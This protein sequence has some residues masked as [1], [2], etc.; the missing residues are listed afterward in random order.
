M[1]LSGWMRI[2]IIAIALCGCGQVPPQS[3]APAKKVAAYP[4]GLT[5][6]E[7]FNL[8]SKCAEL[9]DKQAQILGL[10]GIALT[11]EV[12]SHYNPDTNRCYAETVTTKNFSFTEKKPLPDN[13]LTT[14]LHDAQTKKL[15]MSA[16]QEGDKRVG[17][18]YTSQDGLVFDYDKVL[19]QINQLMQEDAVQ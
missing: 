2:G 13:Y 14:S 5:A 11:S 16:Q 12:V 7:I 10:V 6:T 4:N 18:D 15:M 19:G 9:V 1:K 8:R 3:V 17:Y